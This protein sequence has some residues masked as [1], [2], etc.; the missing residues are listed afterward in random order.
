MSDSTPSHAT[1][2]ELEAYAR[3]PMEYFLKYSRFVP[4]QT[5]DTPIL[6]ELPGNM[7]GDLVHAV[8]REKMESPERDVAEITDQIARGRE[9]PTHLVPLSDVETMCMR[10]LAH[11]EVQRWQEFHTEVPFVMRLRD[12]LLHGTIDF[13]GRS[14][15]G[16]HINDYK[17]DRLAAKA[18]VQ[19]RAKSYTLQMQAYAAAAT[20][21]GLTPLVDTTLLFLRTDSAVTQ[22]V[23]PTDGAAVIQTMNC[24]I[25]NIKTENWDTGPTPPCTTCPFHHNQMCWEDR[26][27]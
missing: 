4:A 17:T 14:Q 9:M 18:S 26:L 23:S 2:S 27:K 22:T 1:V 7:L 13:L 20:Q 5:F 24:I 6:T 11:H 19:E 21:A 15:T 10:A 8:I 16:W 25:E 3:C 12:T